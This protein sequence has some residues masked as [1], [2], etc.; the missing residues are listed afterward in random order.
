MPKRQDINRILVIGAGPIVIGQAGEFDYSGSQ[1]VK[2][3]K[4]LGY[5]VVVLN[6]NP[7]TIMT[8]PELSDKVYIEPINT[9]IIEQIIQNE[10]ID[11]ILPTVGGQ[12]ALNVSLELNNKGLIDKYGI[13]LLGV[14]AES[15]AKAEHRELFRKSIDNIGLLSPKGRTVKSLK[16][17]MEFYDDVGLPLIIRPSLTL[18]GTGGGVAND[19][20][21]FKQIVLNGLNLSPI[22]EVL[23]EES[24]IGWKEYEFEVIRDNIDNAIIV[25]SI[26]NFDPMGVHTGDSITVAPAQTLSDDEYQKLRD[27]SIAII[28]EIG[29]ATGGSNI[30][31]AVNPLNG[32]VRVIEMNPSL[33][34]NFYVQFHLQYYHKGVANS[35][36][37]LEL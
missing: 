14:S 17:A 18:G 31:F 4:Q 2:A 20:E 37:N 6:S 1:A 34:V 3:L 25:A 10:K 19:L 12:T 9:D 11:A 22:S 8:D 32:E 21:S 35:V 15:I 7:A 26:E 16:E 23:V 5:N 28:R 33:W 24:L 13:E 36:P 27:Y 30:Q 29:V